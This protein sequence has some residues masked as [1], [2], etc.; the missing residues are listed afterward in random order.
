MILFFSMF[1]AVLLNQKFKGRTFVRAVFFLPV[2]ITSG[3][4]VYVLKSDIGIGI[5]NQAP[6]VMGMPMVLNTDF[7]DIFMK[8]LNNNYEL[9]Q[10]LIGMMD[11]VFVI[12]WRSGVQILIFLAGLQSIPVSVH[13]SAFVDGATAWESFWKITFP[14]LSPI[15]VVNLAYTIIDSFTDYNNEILRYIMNTTFGKLQFDL[16][17]TYAWI[18]FVFILIIISISLGITSRYAFYYDK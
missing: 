12:M 18:Y 7:E 13:E 11:R 9:T 4:L 15:I 1:I 2:V 10:S 16:G 8:V 5:A 6:N 17:A 14:M 3:A